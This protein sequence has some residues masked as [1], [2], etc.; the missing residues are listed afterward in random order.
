MKENNVLPYDGEAIL[1]HDNS[2]DFDWAAV[3]GT[4]IDTIPWRAE[5]AQLFGRELAVPRL[6]AWFGDAA[7][8]YSGILHRPA[9][10]P[11][12]VERL[13]KRAEGLSGAS[14]NAVLLNLYRTGRDSVGWHSDH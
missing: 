9:P 8:S 7:Y 13:R 11:E 3:T 10:F 12:I 5:T 1:F 4:L 14:F 2:A 6:T